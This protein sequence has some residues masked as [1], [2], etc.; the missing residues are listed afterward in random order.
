M[1][2]YKRQRTFQRA[3]GTHAALFFS[4]ECQVQASPAVLVDWLK[5]GIHR[6]DTDVA[7]TMQINHLYIKASQ[8]FTT[9]NKYVTLSTESV[10]HELFNKDADLGTVFC[11]PPGV[12]VGIRDEF[13][14]KILKD[15]CVGNIRRACILVPDTR[16][17][18]CRL[19]RDC[20]A[21]FRL[22]KVKFEHMLNGEIVPYAA[23]HYQAW[24]VAF[25][26][27]DNRTLRFLDS[28]RPPCLQA[29]GLVPARMNTIKLYR[30]GF[31]AGIFQRAAF[32]TLLAAEVRKRNGT[33]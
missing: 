16:Y 32:R 3:G 20:T 13:V 24:L 6:F 19:L 15:Y 7:S 22:N 2:E 23:P 1:Q 9:E 4:G 31:R 26:G 12:P 30:E 14:I 17:A 25:V 27:I 5:R 28:S 33:P 18:G 11:N 21:H 10:R 29:E 8:V